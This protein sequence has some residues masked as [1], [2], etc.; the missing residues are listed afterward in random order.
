MRIS[1]YMRWRIPALVSLGVNF[2]LAA[3][4]VLS[5]R[6]GAQNRSAP[7]VGAA[8]LSNTQTNVVMRRQMFSW[9]AVESEDYPTYI[10]NL[11]DIG[12]PDQTIRDIII[13]DVNALYTRRRALEMATPEQQWWRS[14]PDSNVRQVEDGEAP[15]RDNEHPRL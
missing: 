1:N 11:H 10:A 13:A 5:M 8:S 14:E 12:C 6:R 4:L 2:A 15:V 3:G 7:P 9:R